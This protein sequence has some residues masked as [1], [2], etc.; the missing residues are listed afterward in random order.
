MALLNIFGD[1]DDD[2]N[3]ASNSK[4]KTQIKNSK[5]KTANNDLQAE[6]EAM[7]SS[8]DDRL[9]MVESKSDLQN[10]LTE[11]T[12]WRTKFSETKNAI[13]RI[14][15]WTVLVNELKEQHS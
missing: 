12:A 3:L 15:Q 2:G 9:A 6:A 13:T 4:P 1:E 7:A 11:L 10:L 14:D 8:I 5:S